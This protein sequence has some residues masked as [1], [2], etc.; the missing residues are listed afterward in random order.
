MPEVAKVSSIVVSGWLLSGVGV[1]DEYGEVVELLSVV[2]EA[3]SVVVELESVSYGS[4]L[5]G[6]EYSLGAV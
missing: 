3:V 5:L 2:V 4:V 1:S 6:S